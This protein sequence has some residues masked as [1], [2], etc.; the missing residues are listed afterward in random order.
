MTNQWRFVEGKELYD[1][2]LDPAQKK[3]IAKQHPDVIK[4]LKVSYDKWWKDVYGSIKPAY[5]ISIG[6]KAKLLFWII[7]IASC[8]DKGDNDMLTTCAG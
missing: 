3:N 6:S 5:E 2:K 8:L 4:K 7:Y 1:I